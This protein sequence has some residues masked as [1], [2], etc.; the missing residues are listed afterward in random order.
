MGKYAQTCLYCGHE[1]QPRSRIISIRCPNC[2]VKYS[3]DDMAKYQEALGD[4]VEQK[5][6]EEKNEALGCGCGIL[7]IIGL[8]WWIF[9]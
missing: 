7:L 3:A 8:L 2:G 6:E 4:L 5:A 9:K 1:W